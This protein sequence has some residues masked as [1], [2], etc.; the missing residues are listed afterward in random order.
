[1]RL[2]FNSKN[3]LGTLPEF[4]KATRRPP[5]PFTKRVSA[6]REKGKGV[7]FPLEVRRENGEILIP[8]DTYHRDQTECL[9]RYQEVLEDYRRDQV[10]CERGD[11][12]HM[13]LI[14]PNLEHK[15]LR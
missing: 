6:C 14:I 9:K 4:P 15:E 3:Q 7:H 8:H 5:N 1:M 12:T 13:I 11:W 10:R 2:A